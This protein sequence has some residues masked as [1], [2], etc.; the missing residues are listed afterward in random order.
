MEQFMK[1][2]GDAEKR[3]EDGVCVCGG[4]RQKERECASGGLLGGGSGSAK[5]IYWS[6][7]LRF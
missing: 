7:F 1:R 6:F 5:V 3:C 2:M 4:E